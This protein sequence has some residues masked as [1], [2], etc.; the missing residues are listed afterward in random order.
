ML[1]GLSNQN[2]GGTVAVTDVAGVPRAAQIF[3]H[4]F[5][6]SRLIIS[7]IF[8]ARSLKSWI[9]CQSGSWLTFC[10][11]RP[12]PIAKQGRTPPRK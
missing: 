7:S 5:C 2:T 1:L 6:Q 12:S 4:T 10:I 8:L 3:A 11:N 9:A